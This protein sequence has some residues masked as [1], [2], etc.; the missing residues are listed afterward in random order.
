MPLRQIK[1][2]FKNIIIYFFI[3]TYLTS[4]KQIKKPMISQQ[5]QVTTLFQLGI[6]KFE[7]YCVCIKIEVNELKIE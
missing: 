2:F 1:I 6:F 7:L 5:S 4:N 3:Y